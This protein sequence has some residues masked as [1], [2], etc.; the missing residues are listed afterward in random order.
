MSLNE[1]FFETMVLHFFH[2]RHKDFRNKKINF[3]EKEN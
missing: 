2:T 3:I 1:I